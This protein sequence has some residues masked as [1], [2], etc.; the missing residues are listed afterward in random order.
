MIMISAM[1]GPF[2]M[3]KIERLWQPIQKITKAITSV[4]LQPELNSYHKPLWGKLQCGH[5][6]W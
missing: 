5:L 4:L 2:F 3:H 1:E 6:K